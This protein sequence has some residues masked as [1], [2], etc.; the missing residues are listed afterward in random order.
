MSYT[1]ICTPAKEWYCKITTIEQLMA[2]WSEVF[3]PKLKEALSSIRESIDKKVAFMYEIEKEKLSM[4][5][6]E[7]AILCEQIVDD[8]L[9]YKNYLIYAKQYKESDN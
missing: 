8:L 3:N 9:A 7:D 6:K 4:D 2:Y 5:N 1:F